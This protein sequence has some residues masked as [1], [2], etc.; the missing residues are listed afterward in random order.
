[1]HADATKHSKTDC[2]VLPSLKL[3]ATDRMIQNDLVIFTH[4]VF[5]CDLNKTSPDLQW[6]FLYSKMNIFCG[7]RTGHDFKIVDAIST[8]MLSGI[9]TS[10]A[11]S[12]SQ[13]ATSQSFSS[14]SVVTKGI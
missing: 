6:N 9:S 8:L 13:I 11:F 12:L 1:M 2:N 14:R 10:A 7:R 5:Y 3:I 4:N